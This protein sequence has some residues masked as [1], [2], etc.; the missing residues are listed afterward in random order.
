MIDTFNAQI[1]FSALQRIHIFGHHF[2]LCREM[3]STPGRPCNKVDFPAAGAADI[4]FVSVQTEIQDLGAGGCV[5]LTGKQGLH[6]GCVGLFLCIN[7]DPAAEGIMLLV[8]IIRCHAQNSVAPPQQQIPVNITTAGMAEVFRTPV[9]HFNGMV[10]LQRSDFLRLHPGPAGM[11]QDH[12]LSVGDH[13]ID[14]LLI[15]HFLR[16]I[17]PAGIIRLGL[18]GGSGTYH[19]N[20]VKFGISQVLLHT[21]QQ[22]KI[23]CCGDV[24]D[25]KHI[26][27]GH[28]N[29][30]ISMGP[31][32]HRHLFRGVH[33]VGNRGMA[34]KISLQPETVA[35]EIGFF[36]IGT[37]LFCFFPFYQSAGKK[38]IT[39]SVKK[40]IP[41]RRYPS[42]DPEYTSSDHPCSSDS[43]HI[44]TR[45]T[46][47]VQH[48]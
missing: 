11:G 2:S 32:I 21:G 19:M 20:T 45:Y 24:M 4:G 23:L 44:G 30:I 26:M 6:N 12:K 5:E 16:C 1:L 7:H 13:H 18:A 40:R 8:G 17:F 36:H 10:T 3:G 39:V 22:Q 42:V 37:I 27:I 48:L 28:G 43:I 14:Q 46:E 25:N 9:E 47:S 15:S 31:V 41:I 35:V 33:T 29:E 34:V 38:S